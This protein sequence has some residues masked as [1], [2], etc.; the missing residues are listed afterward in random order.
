MNEPRTNLPSL[1]TFVGG[2][3]RDDDLAGSTKA[4]RGSTR[5]N[6]SQ[7]ELR[8]LDKPKQ[9]CKLKKNKEI[10]RAAF[11]HVCYNNKI[12]IIK[13]AQL[14]NARAK[15]LVE[16]RIFSRT[17]LSSEQKK[18]VLIL[19]GPNLSLEFRSRSLAS[20]SLAGSGLNT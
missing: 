4:A 7:P 2:L 6:S 19:L 16:S 5:K 18:S 12:I 8:R 17:L 13:S 14:G 9:A 3:V 1:I 11:L 15:S 10:S 20:L